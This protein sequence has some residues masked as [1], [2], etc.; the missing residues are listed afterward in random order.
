MYQYNAIP[1][2]TGSVLHLVIINVLMYFGTYVV[3]GPEVYNYETYRI[4]ELG[5]LQL[6]SFIPGSLYWHP[7]QIV[8]NLFMHL[9]VRHLAFNMFGLYY[10]GAL[11]E[12]IWGPKR[13]VFYYLSCGVA[14]WGAQVAVMWREQAGFDLAHAQNFLLGASGSVFG[15]LVAYAYLFPNREVRLF[16]PPV[17]LKAKYFALIMAGLEFLYGTSG[18]QTGIG[19]FAHLGGA[20][21]G[22]LLIMY[23]Y[24]GRLRNMY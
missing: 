24:G 20:V 22:F 2:L 8:T 10:F 23:W 14:A 4:E 7:Y 11:V 5:R 12:N 18:Q 3:L 1:P 19:H 6:A 9:D 16:F 17:N 13:F 15:L 21:F